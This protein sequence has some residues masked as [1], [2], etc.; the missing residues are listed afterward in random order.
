VG[1]GRGGGGGGAAYTLYE[2][3]LLV[4]CP[5][6]SQRRFWL[7]QPGGTSAEEVGHLPANGILDRI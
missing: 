3:I 6:V 5:P 7:L 1:G 2:L 4:P